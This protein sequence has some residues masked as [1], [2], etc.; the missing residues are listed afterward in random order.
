MPDDLHEPDGAARL[1]EVGGD[2]RACRGVSGDPT[3]E[4]DGRHRVDVGHGSPERGEV[5]EHAPVLETTEVCLGVHFDADVE[6][7]GRIVHLL[8]DPEV[9][10][11]DLGLQRLGPGDLLGVTAERIRVHHPP[12]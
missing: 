11:P 6:W 12:Q 8:E 2:R 1:V 3:G 7:H 10:D 9:L 4:V 5:D